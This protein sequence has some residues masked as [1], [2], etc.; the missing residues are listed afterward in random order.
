MR[1]L[2]VDDVDEVRDGLIRL[3][4]RVPGIEVVGGARDGAEAVA[5]TRELRPAVVLMDMRMPGMDGLTATKAITALD[6][7]PAVIVL[8]AYGDESLVIEA[9]LSG[10]AATWSRAP[11]ASRWPRPCRRPPAARPGWPAR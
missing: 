9:L 7:P 8:S 4:N 10:R 11:A 2:V 1:T 3:M 5:L 6:D